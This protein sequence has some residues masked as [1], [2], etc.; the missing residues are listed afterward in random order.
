MPSFVSKTNFMKKT[1]ILFSFLFPL[2]FFN[3]TTG[4]EKSVQKAVDKI[5]NCLNKIPYDS[6]NPKAYKDA[7]M[8]CFMVDAA[9]N[10]IEIAQEKHVNISDQDAMRKIGEEVG[11]ELIKQNCQGY[12]Q[13]SIVMAKMKKPEEANG[14]STTGTLTRMNVKEFEYLVV[15][16]G[17][18][19]EETFLW[20]TN[21]DGSEKF[22]GNKIQAYMGKQV[23]IGWNEIEVYMPALHAY[24]KIKQITSLDILK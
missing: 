18:S 23:Q 12:I 8:N 11:Q 15:K 17:A 21:F 20:L 22:I 1:A 19:K 14:N 3:K 2:C 13:F 9:S 4:Q 16:T 7:A 5:C 6:T 10:Y 24:R